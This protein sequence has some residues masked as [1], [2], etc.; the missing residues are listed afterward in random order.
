MS[1]RKERYYHY[2]LLQDNVQKN[3][4]HITENF[5]ELTPEQKAGVQAFVDFQ[6]K[7]AADA[8]KFAADI[9]AGTI[10][11]TP[12][13]KPELTPEQNKILKK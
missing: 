3:I 1:A 2:F 8:N 5:S 4:N 12:E 9:R 10:T 13:S 6:V 7:I 11:P